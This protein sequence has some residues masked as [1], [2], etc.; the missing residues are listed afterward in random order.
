MASLAS[1]A[2][3]RLRVIYTGTRQENLREQTR[4]SSSELRPLISELFRHR[5]AHLSGVVENPAAV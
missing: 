1:E 2:E 3:G 4:H 5:K